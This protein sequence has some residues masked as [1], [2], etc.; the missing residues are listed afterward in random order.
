MHDVAFAERFNAK[1]IRS[2]GRTGAGPTTARGVYGEFAVPRPRIGWAVKRS[3]SAAIRTRR[4]MRACRCGVRHDRYLRAGR[5]DDRLG[6]DDGSVAADDRKFSSTTDSGSPRSCRRR[7][8][9]RATGYCKSIPS[10]A[11]RPRS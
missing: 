2:R 9:N 1:A 8:P 11:A 7:T 10:F 4:S 5:P 3:P 6:G